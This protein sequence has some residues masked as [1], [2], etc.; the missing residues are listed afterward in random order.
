MI[1]FSTKVNELLP[2]NRKQYIA[3]KKWYGVSFQLPD[4]FEGKDIGLDI[5]LTAYEDC[6]KTS[7]ITSTTNL[8]GL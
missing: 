4:V 7:S 5:Y 8:N 1:E 3:L 2:Y 6:L